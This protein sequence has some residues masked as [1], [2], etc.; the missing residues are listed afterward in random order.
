MR[1]QS[2][3]AL[4]KCSDCFYWDKENTSGICGRCLSWKPVNE[5]MVF[6]HDNWKPRTESQITKQ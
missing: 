2:T 4:N 1:K 6:N 3:E 5:G